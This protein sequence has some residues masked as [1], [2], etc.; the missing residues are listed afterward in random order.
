LVGYSNTD[1]WI[2]VKEVLSMMWFATALIPPVIVVV[3]L[4][5]VIRWMIKVDEK[6]DMIMDALD[7][8]RKNDT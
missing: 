4:Y 2:H 1:Y 6:L 8:E 7:I 5:F 3:G